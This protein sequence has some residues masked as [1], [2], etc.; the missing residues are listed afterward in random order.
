MNFRLS[1][2]PTC[3]HGV[4]T[5]PWH[6]DCPPRLSR[7]AAQWWPAGGMKGC[8]SSWLWSPIGQGGHIAWVKSL[9]QI[10]SKTFW[11]LRES[12]VIA[13]QTIL[14]GLHVSRRGHIIIDHLYHYPPSLIIINGYQ[15]SGSNSIVYS[16]CVMAI[17]MSVPQEAFLDPATPA[18]RT[19]SCVHYD[20]RQIPE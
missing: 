7:K 3:L 16:D 15:T 12:L 18:E 1:N 2:D 14:S 11:P 9:G 8:L 19:P 20:W 6:A 13:S 10:P 5:N 17:G 4:A